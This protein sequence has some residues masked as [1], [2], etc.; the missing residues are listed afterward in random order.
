MRFYIVHVGFCTRC[1]FEVLLYADGITVSGVQMVF[2]LRVCEHVIDDP[3]TISYSFRVS[4]VERLLF[5]VT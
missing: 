4:F 1:A 3:Q 2:Q 5:T